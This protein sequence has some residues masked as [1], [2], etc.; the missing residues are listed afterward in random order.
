M[1][2]YLGSTGEKQYYGWVVTY[3]DGSKDFATSL[4]FALYLCKE[5]RRA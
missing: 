5:R 3:S 2:S 1:F 4:A